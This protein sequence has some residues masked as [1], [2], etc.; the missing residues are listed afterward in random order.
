MKKKTTFYDEPI[1][2][3]FLGTDAGVSF[4]DPLVEHSMTLDLGKDAT[5]SIDTAD[6]DLDYFSRENARFGLVIEGTNFLMV[7]QN[8]HITSRSN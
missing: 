1:E 5:W 2:Q 7:L 6:Y 3:M 8:R 4:R